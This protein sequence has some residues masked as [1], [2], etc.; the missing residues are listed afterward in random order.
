VIQRRSFFVVVCCSVLVG[1]VGAGFAHPARDRSGVVVAER[2]ATSPTQ[3]RQWCVNR[4]N[5]SNMR[6]PASPA[7]V[8]PRCSIVLAYAF[9]AGS[10]GCSK[11]QSR[12]GAWC[13]DM[14]FGFVCQLNRYG[15]YACPTHA[16]PIH[17]TSWNGATFAPNRLILKA[18][19]RSHVVT[20]APPWTRLPHIDGFIRP[21][22]L[23]GHL[24]PGLRM[25]RSV[26]ARCTALSERVSLAKRC[27]DS[28]NYA[29]RLD[30]CFS[31]P[32]S[33]HKYACPVAAGA[34]RYELVTT[35]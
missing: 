18:E 27:V 9:R 1:L 26:A 29:L 8:T 34:T 33:Q 30:P 12:E 15:A 31:D 6:W 28:N 4:W 14:S 21:W 19:F 13:I 23:A 24:R 2:N 17:V 5:Q 16:K 22:T 25:A 20:P 32:R 35:P 3:S 10:A 7:S 11:S